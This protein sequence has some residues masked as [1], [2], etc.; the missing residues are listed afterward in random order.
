MTVLA[1]DK[2]P[3]VCGMLDAGT[4]GHSCQ[5]LRALLVAGCAVVVRPL[6]GLN[7]LLLFLFREQE[8]YRVRWREIE[9]A[10]GGRVR[11]HEHQPDHAQRHTE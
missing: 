3:T 11:G 2:E 7:V 6:V 5:A 1:S 9:S 4:Q 8:K 10:R